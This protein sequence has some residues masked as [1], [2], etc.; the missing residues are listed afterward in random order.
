MWAFLS[1]VLTFYIFLFFFKT[2]CHILAER[3]YKEYGLDIGLFQ[4]KICFAARG[5]WVTNIPW[6]RRFKTFYKHGSILSLL[7]IIPALLFLLWNL[8]KICN[9]LRPLDDGQQDSRPV[10][11]DLIFQPVIP[12]VTFP[13][14]DIS[15]YGLSLFT[16][17]VFHE[18]GHALAADS[19]DVKLLGYGLIIMIIIPAAYVDLSTS[20]LTSLSLSDQ[21]KVYTAGI[22][23]NLVLAGIAIL[24]FFTIPFLLSPFYAKNQGVSIIDM[25]PNSSLN[26]ASGLKPGQ[27]L[28]YINDC[29]VFNISGFYRC[30]KTEAEVE[31][32]FCVSSKI[33]SNLEC[34]DCCSSNGTQYLSFKDPKDVH[35]LPVRNITSQSLNFCRHNGT[36]CNQ[37]QYKCL[38]PTLKYPFEKLWLMKRKEEKDFLFIGFSTDIL[39]G[40]RSLTDYM[41]NWSILPTGFPL[42]IEKISYYTCSFS[43]ALALINVIP[44]FMLDGQFIIK[45]LCEMCYPVKSVCISNIFIYFGSGL[46]VANLLLTFMLL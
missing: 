10:K 32:G 12:G 3:I 27:T 28:T 14:S 43:L 16:C 5:R 34:Q 39:N 44:C 41:S 2:R 26:G 11:D 24:L 13:I 20:E 30:L 25:P 4:L 17:T 37:D 21:L 38:I 15:V 22:W 42:M 6:L 40:V 45:S 1:I 18:L 23:H 8:V 35:C 33:L 36:E 19:L 46:L 29:P 31:K 9:L 7:L